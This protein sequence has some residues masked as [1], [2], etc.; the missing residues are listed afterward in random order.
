M[1]IIT[2]MEEFCLSVSSDDA[3]QALPGQSEMIYSYK[4]VTLEI[5]ECSPA[6]EAEKTNS[7]S[8]RRTTSDMPVSPSSYRALCGVENCVHKEISLVPD[9]D[10]LPP[11]L[12]TMGEKGKG[13]I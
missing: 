4:P 3:Q 7:S 1:D 5:K 12:L 13:K 11:V 6:A 8:V 2:R 9:S 10:K